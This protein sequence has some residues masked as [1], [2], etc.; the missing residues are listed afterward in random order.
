MGFPLLPD[1]DAELVRSFRDARFHE[2]V[3][4]NAPCET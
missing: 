4:I 2:R 1:V 3:F